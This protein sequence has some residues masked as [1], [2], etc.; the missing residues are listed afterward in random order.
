MPKSYTS[1]YFCQ[2][3]KLSGLRRKVSIIGQ[4]DKFPYKEDMSL[5]TN[6]WYNIMIIDGELK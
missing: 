2:I 4:Y 3:S 5:I 6:E 1:I